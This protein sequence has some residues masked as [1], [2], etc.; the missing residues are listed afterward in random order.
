MALLTCV[1]V[2]ITK[3]LVG[4]FCFDNLKS[5]S[6]TTCKCISCF[7]GVGQNSCPKALHPL[8]DLDFLL[9][10]KRKEYKVM[11]ITHISKRHQLWFEGLVSEFPAH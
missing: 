10:H 5:G 11:S 8:L 4:S 2:A 7:E 1:L 6:L 9:K 3:G